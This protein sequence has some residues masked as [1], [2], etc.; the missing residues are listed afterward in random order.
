MKCC[1]V[2]GWVRDLLLSK[3]GYPVHPND[4]DWVV[5]GA[6]PEEMTS[7]GFI[8]VG[9]DFPVFLHPD[10]HEEYALAR[11]ERKIAKGYHGFSFYTSPEITLEDD[12][13]RRDLTIN[14]MAI[15]EDGSLVDPH[16]GAD[17]LKKRILRHVSAAFSEDPVRILRLARFQAKFP[18]FTIAA[19]TMNLLKDMVSAG[20]ADALT[21]ERIHQ[22]L[23]KGLE[24][25]R[26][27]KMMKVLYDCGFWQRIF[28]NA[29]VGS[30]AMSMIDLAS[31]RKLS[32]SARFA[33]FVFDMSSEQSCR[34]LKKIRASSQ[35]MD[36]A[37]TVRILREFIKNAD[38]S[39]NAFNKLFYAVDAARRPERL[40]LA[41]E[42]LN[43][44]GLLTPFFKEDLEDLA[45]CWRNIDSG[46][47]AAKCT[48][49]SMI[50]HAVIEA[51]CTAISNHPT[52]KKYSTSQD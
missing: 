18:D 11:T 23:S 16:H 10:T 35:Q 32:L 45:S 41:I 26:P 51:R 6:T 28:P 40:S 12:L 39:N 9:R 13:L 43:E 46:A 48:D 50:K 34:F 14:A 7:Q 8:P 36:S 49:K 17:D 42:V 5:V 29:P 33:A 44:L 3:D 20:E 15:D 30:E 22:E 25:T 1:V 24:S 21:P 37:S 19:E 27:S 47:I 31:E 4:R 52:Y 2:G 38:F